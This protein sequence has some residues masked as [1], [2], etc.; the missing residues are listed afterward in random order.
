MK[1]IRFDFDDAS[2]KHLEALQKRFHAD[3]L[4]EAVRHS[5]SIAAFVLQRLD[6]G[7]TVVLRKD[8]AVD[9]HVSVTL[10]NG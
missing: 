5:M 10:L 9:Q 8:G 4:A 2:L 6:D 1:S 7:Y 3:T